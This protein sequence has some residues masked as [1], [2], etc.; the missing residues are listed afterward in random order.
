MTFLGSPPSPVLLLVLL[1]SDHGSTERPQS[2][3]TEVFSWSLTPVILSFCTHKAHPRIMVVFPEW[4]EKSG[5]H[6]RSCPQ[7]WWEPVGAGVFEGTRLVLWVLEKCRLEPA[8]VTGVKCLHCWGM[9]DR[10]GGPSR[11]PMSRSRGL[12]R[13]L[14]AS[15]PGSAVGGA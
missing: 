8:A 15:S 1:P 12:P 6:C 14:V 4:W 2:R 9:A 7:S 13:R 5:G 3:G 10:T 11:E